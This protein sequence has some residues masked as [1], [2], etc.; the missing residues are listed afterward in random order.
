[1][2]NINNEILVSL[3]KSKEKLSNEAIEKIKGFVFSSFHKDGA[4]VDRAGNPDVYYSVFAYSLAYVFDIE[5]PI[6]KQFNFIN[7][8][9]KNNKPDIVH[10]ISLFNCIVLISAIEKKRQSKNLS[11]KMSYSNFIKNH[12]RKNIIKKIKKEYSQLFDIIQ[13]YKYNPDLNND[14]SNVYTAFLLGSLYQD[15]DEKKSLEIF[16]K[17]ISF[18]QEDGAFVNEKASKYGVTSTSSAGLA[19]MAVI[20]NQNIEKTVAW[21]NKRY[22]SRGGFKAAENLPIADLLST[23]TALFALKI[24]NIPMNQFMQKSENFINLH[25]DCSGGFFGSIADM[26]A[27]CE[28]T[29]YALLGLGS[30]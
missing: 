20:K 25:W 6:D 27:D 2:I 12:V 17:A 23:A 29:Y 18:I 13:N 4:S 10:A 30:I 5:I 15:I 28:Y 24:A 7:S 14:I 3:E 9:L 22:N 21:L 16:S 8:Y 26:K 11:K 1:M 19:M